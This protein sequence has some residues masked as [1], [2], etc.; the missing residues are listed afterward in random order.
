MDESLMNKVWYIETRPANPLD[1]ENATVFGGGLCVDP[2]GLILTV[3]SV[4]TIPS[5]NQAD[6]IIKARPSSDTSLDS[7]IVTLIDK[8]PQFDLALLQVSIF[9]DEHL[10]F[11]S[12]GDSATVD[13]ADTVYAFVHSNGFLYSGVSGYSNYPFPRDA[14]Y[15]GILERTV[16]EPP[17]PVALGRQRQSFNSTHHFR[18]VASILGNNDVQFRHMHPRLPLVQVTGFGRDPGCAGCPLFRLRD[19]H[20][21]GLF[22]L[23]KHDFHFIIPQT[24]L[25]R[26]VD[27]VREKHDC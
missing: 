17:V 11:L 21:I 25:K 23:R 26:F 12:L 8:F 20:L 16:I 7:R 18:T 22:S 6:C 14:L 2:S 9:P 10:D 13:A 15:P 1:E 19:G 27:H 24:F 4:V 5:L 3:A